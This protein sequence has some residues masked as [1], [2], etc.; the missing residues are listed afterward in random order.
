MKIA[1]IYKSKR[2]YSQ[3]YAYWLL[4]SIKADLYKM[5]EIDDKLI[6]SYDL[7]IYGGGLYADKINGLKTLYSHSTIHNKKLIVYSVGLSN[8][9]KKNLNNI[10]VKN[11]LNDKIV[12]KHFH[13]RGGI[14]INKIKLHEKVLLKTIQSFIV[15]SPK[16]KEERVKWQSDSINF[17]SIDQTNELVAYV[18]DVKNRIY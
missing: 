1:I 3:Q 12:L 11:N 18:N 9:N 4:E 2:G 13:F 10:R 7:I 16:F 8:S 17:M 14:D 5:D 15:K 6:Q